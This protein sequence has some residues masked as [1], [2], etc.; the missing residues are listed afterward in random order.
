MHMPVITACMESVRNVPIMSIIMIVQL[1]V[2]LKLEFQV[3]G[4]NEMAISQVV[5]TQAGVLASA[6]APLSAPSGQATAFLYYCQC[7][8]SLPVSPARS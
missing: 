1:E 4:S 7:V 5:T 2:G 6:S 3:G 8:M